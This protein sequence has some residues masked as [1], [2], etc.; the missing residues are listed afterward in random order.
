LGTHCSAKEQLARFSG[1]FGD[2]LAA[3]IQY[4]C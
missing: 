1:A 2:P 3:S 4:E